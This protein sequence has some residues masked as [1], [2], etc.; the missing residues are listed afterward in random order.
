M[1]SSHVLQFCCSDYGGTTTSI[2]IST[3]TVALL[4]LLAFSPSKCHLMLPPH[5]YLPMIK[6]FRKFLAMGDISKI[7]SVWMLLFEL[8]MK[9]MISLHVT[10]TDPVS[11]PRRALLS[12]MTTSFQLSQLRMLQMLTMV[13]SLGMT[14]DLAQSYSHWALT[15]IF[16]RSQMW[17]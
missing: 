5:V 13:I 17:R 10:I 11:C 15:V 12:T 4:W 14:L 2:K 1:S 7:L 3:S 9:T 6:P 8:N 16:R